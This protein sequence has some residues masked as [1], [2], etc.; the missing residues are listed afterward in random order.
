MIKYDCICLEGI[1]KTCKDLIMAITMK[2]TNFKYSYTSR[3]LVSMLAYANMY[4]RDYE[5]SE[6]AIKHTLYVH[7]TADKT[8]WECRCKVANET[9]IDYDKNVKVFNDTFDYLAKKHKDFKYIVCNTSETSVYNI[10]KTIIATIE[11]LNN[12]AV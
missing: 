10:T 5:Y 12:E 2:L 8:D 9:P 1:D 6:D 11:K 7:L 4:N 3:G